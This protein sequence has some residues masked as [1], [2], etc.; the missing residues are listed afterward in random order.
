[1]STKTTFKRVALVAVAAL[2]LGVLASA[3]SNAAPTFAYTTI[4]DSTAG[5]ALIGGQA[6]VTLTP[7]TNTSTLV[8][9]TGVGSVVTTSVSDATVVKLGDSLVSWTDSST[10]NS[11]T[12]GGT[13][14]ITLYSAV[15][16]VTTI[17]ATPLGADGS[18]GTTVTKTVTWVSTLNKNVYDH[19]AAYIKKTDASIT[20]SSVQV[21]DST[22]A[23][24]T[25][26]AAIDI[27]TPKAVIWAKQFTA[28]DTT[29][30]STLAAG[31]GAAISVSISGAGTLGTSASA[32]TGSTVSV[33]GTASTLNAANL[34]YVYSD[35][36]TG[37]ATITITSGTTTYTKTVTF[38][39]T[40]KSYAAD[41]TDG[42]SKN[43]LGVAETATI[44]INALD[45]NGNKV[46]AAAGLTVTSD[47]ATVATIAEDASGVYVITGVATGKARLKFTDGT[48]PA[49]YVNVQVT[50]K[51]AASAVLTF[52]AASYGAGEKITWKVTA[53]DS[54]GNPIADGA[55]AIYSAVSTNLAIAVGTLPGTSLD[56][57]DGVAT[58]SFFAP[59]ASGSLVITTSAG[60]AMD[61]AIAASAAAA[62]AGTT[63]T[64]AKTDTSV[65]IANA[66]ADAAAD[67]ANEATDAANAA[68][69]AALAAADAA[70]AATAAAE[71]ASAAVA[72]LAKSVTKSLTALKKQITALT[73]L[74]NKLLKK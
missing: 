16:G 69:D 46:G 60:L 58:D 29:T 56:F 62:A 67:A 40:A 51:T 68:T 22:T 5:Q 3:P 41:A 30:V 34:F 50:K 4:G 49:L 64:A 36:R 71:D 53:K 11:A 47:T 74:V 21:A 43:Y 37:P 18:P 26:A 32:A 72:A 7:D 59:A 13:Q 14:A 65:T 52:E 17:S 38:V 10:V 54:D 12:T 63:Y 20:T 55:R 31:K 61:S 6:V 28:T 27:T 23:Q 1:M 33:L 48:N 44:T 24:L 2:G 57:V 39:G 45:A 8:S 19:S 73:A 35:G 25:F 15:A 70:D 42:L 66:T 9:V